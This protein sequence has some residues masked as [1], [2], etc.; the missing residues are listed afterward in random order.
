MILTKEVLLFKAFG[1][2]QMKSKN[3]PILIDCMSSIEM[4]SLQKIRRRILQTVLESVLKF[5][6]CLGSVRSKARGSCSLCTESMLAG[7]GL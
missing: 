4:V 3:V 2:M 7:C 1:Y 5:P 6:S